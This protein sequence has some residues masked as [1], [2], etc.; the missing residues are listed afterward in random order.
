M[1]LI[2]KTY[3]VKVPEKEEFDSYNGRMS[4]DWL[5]DLE[6]LGTDWHKPFLEI[7]PYLIVAFRKIYDLNDTGT[8]QNNYF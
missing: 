8:K 4:E 6:P 3:Y 7:A 1:V 2:Y 5:K